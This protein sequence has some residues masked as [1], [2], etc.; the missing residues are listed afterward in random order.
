MATGY[1][2]RR[3]PAQ[4]AHVRELQRLLDEDPRALAARLRALGLPN[5]LAGP[6]TLPP[7]VEALRAAG[8]TVV[9]VR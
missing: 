2:A 8:L 5:V 9:E 4:V 1:V 7:Q 3:S 6:G